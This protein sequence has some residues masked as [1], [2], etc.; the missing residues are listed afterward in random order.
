MKIEYF[1]KMI[2]G[3][4]DKMEHRDGEGS[5]YIML[6]GGIKSILYVLNGLL[7]YFTKGKFKSVFH[8]IY[9]SAYREILIALAK[10]LH[11]STTADGGQGV[12]VCRVIATESGQPALEVARCT[13]HINTDHSGTIS[14]PA[15]LYHP[16]IHA[17]RAIQWIDERK[18]ISGDLSNLII[19]AMRKPTSD[20][21]KPI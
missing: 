12:I 16:H 1:D 9:Q 4:L 15:E 2:S 13:M 21:Y 3:E 20:K 5:T 18:G 11:Q 17:D 19:L 14:P 10:S 8:W 7:D 6:Y